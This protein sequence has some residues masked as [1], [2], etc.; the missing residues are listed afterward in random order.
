M[1]PGE[2]E[3]GDWRYRVATPKIFVVVTFDPEPETE[4]KFD[5]DTELVVITAWRVKR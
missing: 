3:N 5:P 4:T 1:L 2:H